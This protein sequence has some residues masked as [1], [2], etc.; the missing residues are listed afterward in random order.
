MYL[1]VLNNVIDKKNFTKITFLDWNGPHWGR[2]A[3][4]YIGSPCQAVLG[5][6]YFP[7]PARRRCHCS[8]VGRIRAARLNR[9]LV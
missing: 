8:S 4:K 9:I 2:D 7:L 3:A 1:I 5:K 6:H